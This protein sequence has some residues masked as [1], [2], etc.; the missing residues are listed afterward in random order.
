MSTTEIDNYPP[1]FVGIDWADKEHCVYV[2]DS[3]TGSSKQRQLLQRPQDLLQ[4]GTKMRTDY[5]GQPLMICLEQG[6]GPLM[7]TLSSMT[8]L[9]CYHLNPKSLARY[10]EARFPSRRKNDPVD[11]KLLC[12]YVLH[13]HESMRP[14][15]PMDEIAIKLT[16]YT[17]QRRKLVDD[18]SAKLNAL[19][20]ELKLYYP[21]IL[22]WFSVINTKTVWDLL[23]KWPTLDSLK[24]AKKHHLLAF[25][26]AH[27]V[28]SKK[29][30]TEWPDAVQQAIN[31]HQD[32]AISETASMTVLSLCHLLLSLQKSIEKYDT[33]IASLVSSSEDR[34]I[35]DSFPGVGKQLLPRMIAAFGSNRTRYKDA[36]SIQE[37]AGIAP[38]VEASGQASWVHFRWA[39]S[40]FMRQT[41]HEHA[42][43]SIA[44]SVWARNYYL[45]AIEQG[46]KHHVVI[47]ALAF[48]WLRIIFA[49]WKNSTQYDEGKY[50]EQLRKSGSK[51][52]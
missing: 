38:V 44:K 9:T 3:K 11:A 28:R 52:A 36:N 21:Q 10:R 45:H 6:R 16:R 49:C 18:R 29:L 27:R 30:L 34:L 31:L 26:H 37:L 25:L 4:R 1:V 46:R 24:N 41:F 40:R 2:F 13:H 14:C 51:Y 7:A 12:E 39:A 35:F 22:E 48:K 42:V 5:P 32:T 19:R 8:W 47:R 23:L 17:E 20:A 33:V 43:H 15:K 50:L